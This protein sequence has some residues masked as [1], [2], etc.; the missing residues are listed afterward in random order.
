MTV[1]GWS[2]ALRMT[3][4]PASKVI[5]STLFTGIAVIDASGSYWVAELE[6]GAGS[7]VIARLR[8]PSGLENQ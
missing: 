2:S 3:G 1:A 8:I 7:I 5:L 6:A 4:S